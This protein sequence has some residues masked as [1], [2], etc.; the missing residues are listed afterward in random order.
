MICLFGSYS[1]KDILDFFTRLGTHDEHFGLCSKRNMLSNVPL[2]VHQDSV[3]LKR[4]TF[5]VVPTV[6]IAGPQLPRKAVELYLLLLALTLYSI[7]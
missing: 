2:R 5:R 6:T 7:E 1:G 3:L 4:C